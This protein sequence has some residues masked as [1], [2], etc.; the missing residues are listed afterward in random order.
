MSS[1]RA[2]ALLL[3]VATGVGLLALITNVTTI[4]QMSGADQGFAA[5]RKT[6]SKVAN[7]G[8]VW[9]GLAI[10]AGWLV[11]RPGPAVVAGPASALTALVVHYVAG[12]LTGWMPWDSMST[13][14]EWFVAAVVMGPP[15][16]LIGALARRADLWGLLAA[17]AVP[18]GAVLEPIAQGW[19]HPQSGDLWANRLSGMW[20][21]GLLITGGFAFGCVVVVR[22]WQNHRRIISSRD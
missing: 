1:R 9:G 17:L 3:A 22:W 21:G 10:L 13:N 19:L 15:L 5:L 20:A 4:A 2:W 14:L 11:R 16:G 18:T 8:V 7:A 6:A 12:G